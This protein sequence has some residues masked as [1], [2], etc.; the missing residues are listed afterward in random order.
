MGIETTSFLRD[1]H[2]FDYWADGITGEMSS[3]SIM[4]KAV[5]FRLFNTAHGQE[6]LTCGSSKTSCIRNINNLAMPA[7]YSIECN[8]DQFQFISSRRQRAAQ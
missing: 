8:Q 1:C 5:N 4:G 7:D 2:S 3:V 6:F